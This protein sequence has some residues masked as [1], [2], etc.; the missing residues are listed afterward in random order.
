MGIAMPSGCVAGGH[1]YADRQ[2][3][4]LVDVVDGGG[5]GAFFEVAETLGDAAEAEESDDADDAVGYDAKAYE[6]AEEV[7]GGLRLA[8]GEEPQHDAAHA[9]YQHEPPPVVAAFLVV[10]G[11]DGERH[12]LE[13]NPHGEDD[14]EGHFGDQD[15]GGQHE[16]HDDLEHGQQRGGAGIGQEGLGAEAED[17]R[18]H[19][20]HKDDQAHQPG[21]GGKTGSGIKNADN[22]KDDKQHGC[23][24]EVDIYFFH[25]GFCFNGSK[26]KG[27]SRSP[28]PF[29][30][31]LRLP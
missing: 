7:A 15:V 24:D 16:S 9:Q 27:V 5:G 22:A 3:G 20:G 1:R 31:A 10:N 28:A 8:Q 25:D 26:L 23:N 30:K 6:D 14:D 18:R 21:R 17:E 19:A 4:L 13:D 29:V 11:E 2:G 12:T